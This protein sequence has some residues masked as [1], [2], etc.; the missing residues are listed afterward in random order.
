MLHDINIKLIE[1]EDKVT[2]LGGHLKKINHEGQKNNH[3]H[4]TT[5]ATTKWSN[6]GQR[7]K[8]S[9]SR[10]LLEILLSQDV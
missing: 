9:I 6:F 7:T 4:Q 3:E 2:H 10:P 1:R 8:S 5:W